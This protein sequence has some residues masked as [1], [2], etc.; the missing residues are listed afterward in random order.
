MRWQ[1]AVAV[2]VGGF[3]IHGAFVAC[4]GAM[5]GSD[6][7]NDAHAQ[8]VDGGST[9]PVAMQADCTPIT[10]DAGARYYYAGFDVAGFDPANGGAVT[11][12]VCG[13]SCTGASC[14]FTGGS[15][16]VA[17]A[18]CNNNPSV[19]MRPGRIEVYCGADNDRGQTARIWMH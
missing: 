4:S 2:L 18:T 8:N 17:G 7:G 10:T 9:G 1:T 15:F 6:G 19:W 11:A 14:G 12:R 5:G 3:A 13:L 16:G